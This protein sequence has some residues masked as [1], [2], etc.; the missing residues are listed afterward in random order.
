[1]EDNNTFRI[2]ECALVSISTGFKAHSMAELLE[3]IKNIHPGSLYHHFWTR[4][5]RPSFDHPEFHND[6][7]AWSYYST[8]DHVL[9]ERLNLIDPEDFKDLEELRLDL[10]EVIEERIDE[11]EYLPWA[12]AE[13]PF[14]FV[15]SQVVVLDTHRIIEQPEQ[16]GPA[17]ANMS[18]GN[19]FYHFI[20]ARRRTPNGVDDFRAWLDPMDKYHDLNKTLATVDPYFNTLT[21]LKN[22]LATIFI[23]YFRDQNR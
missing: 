21:E 20:D 19:I 8:H 23:E 7:A 6:F 17:V 14:Y 3:H 18:P 13:S 2:K 4:L 11:S 16:L 10:I 15:S 9:A 12:K 1:M 22:Q 5:L